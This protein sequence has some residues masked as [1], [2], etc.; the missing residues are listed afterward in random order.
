MDP[1]T[2]TPNRH[3]PL[4]RAAHAGFVLS[5]VVAGLFVVIAIPL[6]W[7]GAPLADDFNNCVAP[8]ELGVGGFMIASWRQLGAIRPA[9]FLEILVTASVC[10]FLPFG[11]AIVVSL[12]LTLTVALLVRGLLRDL[13]TPAPWADVGAALWLLQPLGTEAGLWPAAL[14]V[15][16][17]LAFALAALRA[18]RRGHLGWAAAANI[19]AALSVEQVILPLVLAAG[20]VAPRG[21]R[22]RS[23]LT[24]GAVAA[25]VIVGFISY[26]GANPRLRVG[27]MERM[28]GLV[29]DPAFYVGFPAVG[30][31][32]HS[33]PLAVL[34]AAPWSAA[35][36]IAGAVIGWRF[37]PYL[38][39]AS[40]SLER[41]DLTPTI[42]AVA[43]VVALAN[44]VVVLA[45]PQQGSPR[46]FTPTW[47]VLVVA[48]A[49]VGATRRWRRPHLLGAAGGLFAAGAL[50]SLAFSVAV[51]L[52]SAEF[53]ERAA[54]VIAARVPE[55]GT[56]A[57][58]GIRR[59]VVEPAPRGGFA[60][61]DF[62]YEWAAE[63]ALQ[64][65]EGRHATVS[66]S[67]ELWDR[68]CPSVPAV[69]AVVRF[70]ELLAR[71]RP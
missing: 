25:A 18:Y 47:L 33:I 22:R 2:A 48:A 20:L 53:T 70:D 69:D 9:R 57:M 6:V 21:Q 55:G 61:H 42:L 60:V 4:D 14:H 66:L 8:A 11:V 56:V 26:P 23:M 64:Y 51:R 38:A 39:A 54:S 36:L 49:I 65:Y 3:I 24:S 12:L 43:A 5:A 68:P 28:A 29:A 32:L 7:R 46:V 34:W 17:G 71:A 1:M 15:P 52:H 41:R 40:S 59:T 63:R 44:V 31:G 16:V 13:G 35:L 30:L 67:G 10:R 50:L 27:L 37:G 45:V 19:A 58:C 62:L